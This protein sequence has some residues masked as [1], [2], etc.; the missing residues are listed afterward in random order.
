MKRLIKNKIPAQPLVELEF[1]QYKNLIYF[2][3]S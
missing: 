3:T 1:Y 2:T